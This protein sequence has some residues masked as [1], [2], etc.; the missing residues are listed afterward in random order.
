M[1]LDSSVYAIN[2]ADAEAPSGPA[3]K[4]IF[5][6]GSGDVLKLAKSYGKYQQDYQSGRHFGGVTITFADGHVKWQ[7]TDIV[8]QEARNHIRASSI[9]SWNV[10]SPQ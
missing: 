1:F 9:S 5:I 8:L 10:T 7:K 3:D 4:P 2:A 6:P